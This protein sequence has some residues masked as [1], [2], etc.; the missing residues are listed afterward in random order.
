M[1][2]DIEELLAL[3]KTRAAVEAASGLSNGAAAGRLRHAFLDLL[4]RRGYFV[5]SPD[6]LARSI[7][8][9]RDVGAGFDLYDLSAA[10]ADLV[11]DLAP[12]RRK[13]IAP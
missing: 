11:P 3:G 4:Q 12:F 13:G 9:I 8:E 7:L 6:E 1:L 5:G 2:P 10:L